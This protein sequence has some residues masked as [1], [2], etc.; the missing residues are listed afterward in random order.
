MTIT[1]KT[2]CFGPYWPSSG[3]LQ[4]NSW[5]YIYIV[6]ARDGE[7]ISSLEDN[8]KMTNKH[9]NMQLSSIVIKAS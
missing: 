9:R 4:E 3:S 5:F 6:C 1:R 2:T 8:L 7:I